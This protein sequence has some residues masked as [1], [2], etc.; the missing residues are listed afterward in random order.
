MAENF[1]DLTGKVAIVTGTSRGLGQYL[2][3]AL[4]RSGAD[5]IITSRSKNSLSGF[6]AEIESLGRRAVPLELDVTDLQSIKRFA[7]EALA[8]FGKIDILV[9]NAGCN[10][11][12]PALEVSWE[13][14]NTILDTNLRGTF[15][16]AQ[17]IAPAG[18]ATT[19]RWV[20]RFIVA[21]VAVTGRRRG[22]AP[23]ARRRG[24]L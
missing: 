8:A 18:P 3:R 11:R 2:G 23:G 10:R 5:L 22:S 21:A 20:S 19:R 13:D 15:F 12:K 24:H 7:Q 6:Q 4:A 1:F 17:A 9:N 16:T 14:W